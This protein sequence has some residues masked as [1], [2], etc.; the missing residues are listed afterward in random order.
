MTLAMSADFQAAVKLFEEFK[1]L[2][3]Q[4]HPPLDKC[5]DLMAKLKVN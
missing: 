3:N 1:I 5:K 2:F 4:S